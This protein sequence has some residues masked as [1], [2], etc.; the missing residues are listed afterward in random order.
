MGKRSRA[1]AASRAVPVTPMASQR[2]D[3]GDRRL[4]VVI[5]CALVAAVLA[6]YLQVRTHD[7]L[8]FDDQKYVT[9]NEHVATG[10][11]FA[12]ARWAMTALHASNWHPVTW[13]SHM[14][15]VQL[16]GVHAG[17]HL[18]VNVLL[19]AAAS[20]LLFLLLNAMTHRPWRAA[21]VAALFA[22]HP[23]HVES[24]AWVSERKDVLSTVFFFLTLFAYVRW[25]RKPSPLLYT[26]ALLA[27]VLGLAT[28]PMVITLPF[29]LLLLDVWPLERLPLDRMP[30]QLGHR[31]LEKLPFFV[32]V[33]P[34]ALLTM[35]AQ[36]HA[37]LP[38]PLATRIGN[39]LLAYV[40]YLRMLVVPIDLAA[41]Y[42]YRTSVN[43]AA[44]AGAAIVLAAISVAVIVLRRSRP[45]LVVGWFW[46]IGTLVPVIGV[47]QVGQQSMADRYTY[48]PSIGLFVA[49]VWLAS[50]FATVRYSLR[51]VVPPVAAAIIIA[52]SSLT[53]VQAGYWKNSETL[54]RHA[55]NVT[56]ANVVAHNNLG[57]AL[58]R[59]GNAVEAANHFRAAIAVNSRFD[60]AHAG[61]GES[62][63]A[64]GDA[65]GAERELRSTLTLNPQNPIA[66]RGLG[67]L[68]LNAG[69]KAEAAALF[70]K[71]LAIA[72]DA[73]T[74]ALLAVA[75]DDLDGAIARYR[76]AVE[77]D[78]G[79]ADQH[80]DLATVLAKKGQDTEAF[81]EYQEALRI[82]PEMY[83]ANMNVGALLS[84]QN[85]MAESIEHFAAA[86][87]L[88]PKSAEPAVYLSL[89]YNAAGRTDDALA[90]IQRAMSISRDDANAL[91][92]TAIR[93]PPDPRNIDGYIQHLQQSRRSRG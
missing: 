15:D 57:D 67:R 92:T 28:K 76:E 48:V 4:L 89:A 50:D 39:A 12:N 66:Y 31:I 19:H 68:A 80:N 30:G 56:R 61:L 17:P 16:F 5:S 51:R 65:T 47:I 40:A 75:R 23:A 74:R 77:R 18:V 53:Y 86:E 49:I 83:D 54:F 7:F 11:T 71:S 29:V 85:R 72:P 27:F 25:T 78:P 20:V 93:M 14:L 59:N 1:K 34:S 2:V 84:R 42:P 22:L 70:E 55:V 69:R 3:T 52:F 36:T 60:L 9:D 82:S 46:F 26:A 45:Y 33:I 37:I 87:R 8:N 32:L 21:V 58:L 6:V 73:Q 43:A 13:I 41:I 88:R 64:L 24:V 81:A 38:V 44:V 90:A 10:L 79:S 63:L 35:R 62:L 91:L